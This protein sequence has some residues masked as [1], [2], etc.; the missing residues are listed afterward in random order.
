MGNFNFNNKSHSIIYKYRPLKIAFLIDYESCSEKLL[1]SI[2]EFS[3]EN[4]GG[5]YFPI[6]PCDG[7]NITHSFLNLLEYIDPDIIISFVKLDDIIVDKIDRLISPIGFYVDDSI[8]GQDSMRLAINLGNPLPNDFLIKEMPNLFKPPFYSTRSQLSVFQ[9]NSD[10]K[11]FSFILR[12]FG[13]LRNL[14]KI[15]KKRNDLEYR[16]ELNDIY[17]EIDAHEIKVGVNLKDTIDRI[18]GKT[19]LIFPMELA[20]IPKPPTSIAYDE[21]DKDFVIGIGD[22]NLTYLY[23]WNRIHIIEDLPKRSFSQIYVPKKLLDD[24]QVLC[25][26]KTLIENNIH[27]YDGKQKI[28]RIIS[29]THTNNEL[30]E[31]AEIFKKDTY[32]NIVIG[33]S[34]ENFK[35]PQIKIRKPEPINKNIGEI[36]KFSDSTVLIPNVGPVSIENCSAIYSRDW[37]LDVSISYKNGLWYDLPKRR[38]VSSIF[39]RRPS[40]INRHGSISFIVK[41][42]EKNLKIEIPNDESIF[43][44]LTSPYGACT[45]R[46]DVRKIKKS[47]ISEFRIADKGQYLSGVLDLFPNLM[48]AYCC[49]SNKFWR[50]L[51]KYFSNINYQKENNQLSQLE[52][53]IKKALQIVVQN[54]QKKIEKTSN[55]LALYLRNLMREEQFEREIDFDGMFELAKKNYE[56]FLNYSKDIDEFQYSD[57]S[58]KSELKETLQDLLNSNIIFQGIKPKCQY[59]GYKNWY[60]LNEIN[61][62]LKC[63]GCHREF[64]FPVEI[65]WFY[66]V[67]E[68]IKKTILF[69]GVMPT[70]LCLGQILDESKSSFIFLPNIELFKRNRSHSSFAELDIICVSDGHFII[71]EVKNSA[72]LF[73]QSDFDKMEEI[74]CMIRPDRIIFYAFE[75]PYER[76]IEHTEKL[77]RKLSSF[78]M[79]VIFLKPRDY[80]IQPSNFLK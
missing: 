4:W 41:S 67:N 46:N 75:G 33:C 23:L 68:L 65:R 29:A 47:E 42:N 53:K 73:N 57:E 39:N 9:M 20:G 17:K 30:N 8:E 37:V 19:N 13:Y 31:I 76:A 51:F 26:I 66:R 18:N 1:N 78:G 58:L 48:G 43:Y 74:A 21:S 55:N 15:Y 44:K 63:S 64:K 72:K 28:I 50:D 80:M 5:R 40:R 14:L 25:S 36:K 38:N 7:S 22:S 61:T 45:Y 34:K 52:G 49:F 16:I 6:L 62:E 10:N 54:P 71:G 32:F 11:N 70:L 2:V 79:D 35:F 77:R 3:L 60:N 24:D 27:R 12:N 56:A 59:C 69:Q